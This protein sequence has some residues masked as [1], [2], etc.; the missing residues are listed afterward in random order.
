MKVRDAGRGLGIEFIRESGGGS[1]AVSAAR[2]MNFWNA[3]VAGHTELSEYRN[4]TGKRSRAAAASYL[5]PVFEWIAA[6]E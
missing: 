3:W 5:L 2:F 1:K 4:S 6:Q